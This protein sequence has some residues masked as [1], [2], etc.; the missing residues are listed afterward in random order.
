MAACVRPF[1]TKPLSRTQFRLVRGISGFFCGGT[2]RQGSGHTYVTTTARA[3]FRYWCGSCTY[4]PDEAWREVLKVK[5]TGPVLTVIS[6]ESRVLSNPEYGSE[7]DYRKF[8]AVAAQNGITVIGDLVPGHTGK[9][10]DF[11]LAIQNEPG[12]PGLYTMVEIHR[13]DWN[14]VPA[15]A[16]GQDSVN[17]SQAVIQTLKDRGYHPVGELD[18]EVFARPGIKESSWSATSIIRCVDGQDRRW[19]YLHIFKQGQPSLNW[20]DPSFAAHR[21]MTADMLHSL[22]VL[23]A[24]GLRLDATMFLGIETGVSDG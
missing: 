16:A 12:F 24:K 21:L 22:E 9:G 2:W 11:H 10:P 19:V 4:R 18:S 1:A 8:V 6:I 13:D 7:T 20:S 23:G 17:L 3:A 14:L 5:N 15:V